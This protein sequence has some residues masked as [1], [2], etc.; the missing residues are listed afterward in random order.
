MQ[1]APHQAR[2]KRNSEQLT[3]LRVETEGN[4]PLCAMPLGDACEGLPTGGRGGPIEVPFL[5][6]AG[7]KRLGDMIRLWYGERSSDALCMAKGLIQKRIP[8]K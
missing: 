6:E 3:C 5:G 1:C 2:R 4:E 7:L 8:G